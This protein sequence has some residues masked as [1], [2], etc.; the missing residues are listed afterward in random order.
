M[1]APLDGGE[2]STLN[3]L[4]GSPNAIAVDGSVVYV[5]TWATVG[6]EYLAQVVSFL[7]DGGG[8]TTVVSEYGGPDSIAVDANFVYW[9]NPGLGTVSR[10][11]RDGGGLTPIA[12]SQSSPSG[13]A[14]DDTYVYWTNSGGTV[15]KA[16][17]GGG[18]FTTLAQS[19]GGSDRLA[20]HG[21][22]TADT[23]VVKLSLDGGNPITLLTGARRRRS[24]PTRRLRYGTEP[25]FGPT[26]SS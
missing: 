23:S 19:G 26:V 13:V 14:V 10:V 7:L 20:T 25:C 11:Q 8:Y 5:A 2:I 4:G 17:L 12:S 18:T 22:W 24:A 16:P 6:S 1:M 15:M 9:A 21:H 3:T